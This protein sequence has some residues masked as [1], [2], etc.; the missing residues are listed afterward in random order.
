[1]QKAIKQVSEK[2]SIQENEVVSQNVHIP[3]YGVVTHDRAKKEAHSSSEL[4]SH[5]AAAGNHAAAA[6]QYER[7]AMFHKA[8]HAHNAPIPP[9]MNENVDPD[10]DFKTRNPSH[11]YHGEV[12]AKHGSDGAAHLYAKMHRV[13]SDVVKE[14]PSVIRDYLDS[15]HGRHLHD[16]KT[17]GNG[18]EESPHVKAYIRKDFTKFKKTYKPEHFN[19]QVVKEDSEQTERKEQDLSQFRVMNKYKRNQA[20]QM[21]KKDNEKKEKQEDKWK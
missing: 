17:Q 13:V 20:R 16:V 3:G 19:E 18:E 11:G 14:H 7:A 1:M 9:K 5:H 21:K 15:V 2:S 10:R 8:L 6:Y 12:A 4:A